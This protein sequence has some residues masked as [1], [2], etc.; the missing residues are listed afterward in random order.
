MAR[1]D[2]FFEMKKRENRREFGRIVCHMEIDKSKLQSNNK[3]RLICLLNRRRSS[4]HTDEKIVN[5][6]AALSIRAH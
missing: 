4:M 2:F 6:F 3:N 1:A 5:N